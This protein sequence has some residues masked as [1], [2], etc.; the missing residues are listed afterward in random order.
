MNI[1]YRIIKM[2]FSQLG[3]F[4]NPR[5]TVRAMPADVANDPMCS[6][7]QDITVRPVM[8]SPP[9]GANGETHLTAAAA[10]AL[11]L[12]EQLLGHPAGLAHLSALHA[13]DKAARQ[14]SDE[15][16]HAALGLD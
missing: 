6:A 1:T 7:W 16:L 3:D 2:E 9:S 15:E 10:E 8:A 14:Q 12:A 13:Q 5:V 4:E 11:R